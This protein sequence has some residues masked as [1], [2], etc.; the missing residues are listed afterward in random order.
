MVRLMFI[1][2]EHPNEG[3]AISCAKRIAE[4]LQRKGF[5]IYV[6]GKDKIP[7]KTNADEIIWIKTNPNETVTGKPLKMS[8]GTLD[9][10]DFRKIEENNLRT[11]NKKMKEYEIDLGYRF[12][13]SPKRYFE[14]NIPFNR[15]YEARRDDDTKVTA[16]EIKA[17]YRDMPAQIIDRIRKH[18]TPYYLQRNGLYTT[19]TTSNALNRKNGLTPEEYGKE[20]AKKILEEVHYKR[21]TGKTFKPN[22]FMPIWHG[23]IK[24]RYKAHIR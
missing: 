23:K 5:R 17:I 2:N 24:R 11:G 16:I 14:A 6:E 9:A 18:T 3:F 21:T 7:K 22:N 12:H 1:V 4:E 10:A 20:I 19:K 13:T 8:E 15:D